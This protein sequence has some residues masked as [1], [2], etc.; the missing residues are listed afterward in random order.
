MNS[1]QVI[2]DTR[3]D[4]VAVREQWQR[5]RA[6][7]APTSRFDP[8]DIEGLPEPTQ[9]WLR[10]SIVPGT[11]AY[12]SVELRMEGEIRLGSWRRFT[13]RQVIRPDQGYVWAARTHVA[14]VPVSGY[15]AMSPTA[16]RMRW[17]AAGLVPVVNAGGTD[18]LTSAAGRLAGE[19]VFVP[20]AYAQASW[21]V[22]EDPNVAIATWRVGGLVNRARLAVGSSGHLL[23]VSMQRWGKPDG[24]R[25]ALHPFGVT[26]DDELTVDGVTIP[27]NV[28]AY[29]HWGTE[30]E[31]EGEFFRARITEA[32]FH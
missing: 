19:C 1:T 18:V 17:R 5:L 28:R 20:T 13:A 7:D 21:D 16:A 31:E 22:R 27:Q 4:E 9:R 26:F 15:D 6:A 14:G 30:R 8:A 11:P 32:R 2:A 24:K 23:A 10:H 25:F 12:S 29:W 3:P